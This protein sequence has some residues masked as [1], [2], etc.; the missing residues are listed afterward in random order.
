MPK[1]TI[2]ETTLPPVNSSPTLEDIAQFLET[3]AA[4]AHRYASETIGIDVLK[5]AHSAANFR[6]A[7]KMVRQCQGSASTQ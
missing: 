7:A 4:T 5:H 3:S 1:E 6:E 2:P